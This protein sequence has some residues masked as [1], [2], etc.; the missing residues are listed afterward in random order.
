MIDYFVVSPNALNDGNAGLYLKYMQSHHVVFMGW[1]KENKFGRMFSKAR[2][3]DRVIVA[4]G[5]NWQKRSLFVGIIDSDARFDKNSG[6]GITQYRDLRSFVELEDDEL[7]FSGQCTYKMAKRIPAIYRLKANNPSDAKVMRRVENV[8]NKFELSYTL[9]EV[10]NWKDNHRVTIPALQRGLVWQ[11]KQVEMLW[12]SIL[13]GFPIGSF[14]ITSS[15]SNKDQLVDHNL[16][17]EYFLLDG[18]QRY[19]AIALGFAPPDEHSKSVLWVDLLP[20]PAITSSRKYWVKVTTASHPWGYANDDNCLVLSWARCRAAIKEFYPDADPNRMSLQEIDLT[21][22][23]PVE[24]R[25]PVLLSALIEAWINTRNV[26]SFCAHV[27]ADLGPKRHLVQESDCQTLAENVKQIWEALHVLNNYRI[28][29]NILN[30]ETI[31]DEDSKR[32]DDTSSLEHLFTRLNTL[33]TPIS[34]YDLRYSAIKAYWS[35]IKEKND[36]LAGQYMPASHLA[37]LAFRLALTRVSL[38]KHPDEAKLA[39]V[40][41]IDLIRKIAS[42]N[43]ERRA[44]VEKLYHDA[45]EASLQRILAAVEVRLVGQGLPRVL[46]TAIA[47]NSPD[48]FLLLM[49]MASAS[50]L[51][52]FDVIGLATWI[53]WFSTGGDKRRVANAVFAALQGADSASIVEAIKRALASAIKNG[54]LH[55]PIEATVDNFDFPRDVFHANWVHAQYQGQLWKPLYDAIAHN[56]ELLIYAERQYFAEKFRYDPAQ[57]DFLKDHNRPWDYDHIMPKIWMSR[58]GKQF[59]KWKI[60]CLQWV[61]NVGNL[62]A[63]PFYINRSKSDAACWIEYRNYPESLHWDENFSQITESALTEDENMAKTFAYCVSHRLVGIYRD[64]RNTVKALCDSESLGQSSF[65]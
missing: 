2:I 33:G 32:S 16:N 4:Q 55:D 26:D 12:D 30:N 40:P 44:A 36:L 25:L 47:L 7:P 35:T 43:G 54:W 17:P 56:K 23:Y 13:R 18:Q 59:G 64:W 51:D 37:L 57:T 22:T 65:G 15:Q 14:V 34:P 11:P 45:S 6:H 50:L 8:L 10:A 27:V 61:G 3:G 24:A 58:Q 39:D 31:A 20:N 48:V 60:F 63:I 52:G 19:N 49:Y 9:K 29:A 41:S 46:R 21:R 28:T 5:A 38:Q 42:E 1:G 62:A 53:H